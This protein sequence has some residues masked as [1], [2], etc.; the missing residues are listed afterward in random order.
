[1]TLVAAIISGFAS[2][3]SVTSIVDF[4]ASLPWCVLT[5]YGAPTR[6]KGS[7]WNTKKGKNPDMAEKK[8]S[9]GWK[10]VRGLGDRQKRSVVAFLVS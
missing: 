6:E 9:G 3:A 7:E 1:M 8:G 4:A 5:V 10:G 2:Y